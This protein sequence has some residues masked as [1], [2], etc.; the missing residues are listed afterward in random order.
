MHFN[1]CVLHRFGVMRQTGNYIYSRFVHY[2]LAISIS[3]I[4]SEH[5]FGIDYSFPK[6]ESTQFAFSFNLEKKIN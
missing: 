4:L 3:I 1:F 6:F 2:F 5:K